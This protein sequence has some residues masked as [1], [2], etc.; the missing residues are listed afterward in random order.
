M[1]DE[2]TGPVQSASSRERVRKHRVR[3]RERELQ[4]ALAA[5]RLVSGR[6]PGDAS[7]SLAAFLRKVSARDDLPP[8]LSDEIDDAARTLSRSRRR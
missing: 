8:E 4:V 1:E 5:A 6:D 2:D 3:E 7:R